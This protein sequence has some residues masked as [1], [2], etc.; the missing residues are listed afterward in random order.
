MAKAKRLT[1]S[2]HAGPPSTALFQEPPHYRNSA[3]RYHRPISGT[4]AKPETGRSVGKS[5]FAGCRR[6]GIPRVRKRGAHPLGPIL[7]SVAQVLGQS[8]LARK[9]VIDDPLIPIQ[10]DPVQVHAE[11]REKAGAEAA[12]IMEETR[13]DIENRKMEALIDVKNQI[14]SMVV[15]VAEKVLRRELNN[16]Q[17]QTV[18]Y[19]VEQKGNFKVYISSCKKHKWNQKERRKRKINF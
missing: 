7:R 17:E 2:G 19:S 6:G 3:G 18:N 16:K 14:G 10:L 5:G 4:A 8:K 13:R 15:D 1:L 9:V 11:A 12:K